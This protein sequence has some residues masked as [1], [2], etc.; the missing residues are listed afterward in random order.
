LSVNFFR[1]SRAV[2]AVLGR[3]L[4]RRYRSLLKSLETGWQAHLILIC[5]SF[6][7]SFAADPTTAGHFQHTGHKRI[8]ALRFIFFR[9]FFFTV[10]LFSTQKRQNYSTNQKS[11]EIQ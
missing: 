4:S 11:I 9:Y 7:P 8:M 2:A 3:N 6:V 1:L 10:I 5:K